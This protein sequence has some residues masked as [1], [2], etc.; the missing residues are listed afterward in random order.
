MRCK[1]SS[2]RNPTYLIYSFKT[3]CSGPGRCLQ[4]VSTIGV[5]CEQLREAE[6]LELAAHPS[7]MHCQDVSAWLH[8]S[9]PHIRNQMLKREPL[10]RIFD[11]LAIVSG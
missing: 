11:Q 1:V 3:K 2:A 7:D 8:P 4:Q 9:T 5:S 10:L 6:R